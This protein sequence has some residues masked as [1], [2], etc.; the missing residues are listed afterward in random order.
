M[1]GQPRQNNIKTDQPQPLYQQVKAYILEKINTGEWPPDTRVYSEKE[2][3]EIMG[4]SRM[5]ANRA[6][7]ELTTEGF[8]VRVQG[9]GT[10]VAPQRTQS[11]LLEVKNIADEIRERGGVHSCDIHLLQA[12]TASAEVAAG[13]EIPV[14]S[15]VFH[16]VILHRENG[17]PMQLA[18]RYVNPAIA[19]D[20]L[21]QD[22]NTI[23]PSEYLFSVATLSEIEH[24]IEAIVPTRQI[25]KHLKITTDEACLVLHRRTWTHGRVSTTCDLYYPGSRFRIG[26]R[27]RAGQN[28]NLTA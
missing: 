22:F 17:E 18:D 13:L 14:G 5:T 8:L 15:R 3:V 7:R 21:H 24:V 19:P 26:G 12:E 25:R 2:L 9:V 27:F 23:T 16:S 11:A 28:Q 1:I 20:Y 10:F 4:I 6:L